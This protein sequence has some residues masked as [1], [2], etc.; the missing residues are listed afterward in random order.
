[1]AEKKINPIKT[2]SLMMLI[3]LLGKVL[4]LI[5]DQ[6]LLYHYGIS[7][8]GEAFSIASMVPRKFLDII[9]A[10][11]ITASFI[12]VFNQYLE[13]KDR[14]KAYGLANKFIT[15]IFI[16]AAIVTAAAALGSGQIINIM[17]AALTPENKMLASD[18]L[19]I[20][21][22]IL[23]ISAVAFSLTG[24]LHSLG[25]FNIPAAMS[26]ISN[27]LIILY[28]VFFLDDFGIYGLAVAFTL[29]WFTQILIQLPFLKKNQFKFL[30]DFNPS[31][32]GIREI[33]SLMLPVMVS[34]WAQPVNVMVNTMLANRVQAGWGLALN[35]ADTLF[36]IISGVFILQVT[37]LIFPRLSRE[38]AIDDREGFGFTMKNTLRVMIYILVPM[39]AGLLIL[40]DPL[41]RLVYQ[42]GQVD[43]ES[44][45]LIIQA[46]SYY[47]IG[48]IGLGFQ[49]VAS[50]G[51]YA[52][53][54]GKTPLVSGI[55]LIIMNG[56][57]SY[58]LLPALNVGGPALASSI[59]ITV[60]AVLMLAV[61]YRGN[62]RVIDKK[63]LRD[64]VFVIIASVIMGLLV[65]KLYGFAAV[66]LPDNF[67][68]QAAAL[69]I[70]V[71]VGVLVYFLLTWIFKVSEAEVAVKIVKK[72]LKI[73]RPVQ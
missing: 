38:S 66:L 5:R 47:S 53:K 36:T 60:A 13:T 10:S 31:D 70:S 41:I 23:L 33:F 57:L 63:M 3:T 37:N 46:M 6:L 55:L 24:I 7:Q 30:F 32:P 67:L 54:D 19:K 20:M 49:T 29:S 27:G 72:A 71:A 4:G 48:I 18:L 42:R 56:L 8:T 21:M 59:S 65:F 16:A 61:L 26:L 28:Y 14:D 52:I 69:L 62:K 11:A 58:A 43:H 34:S 17:G 9:F 44:A 40:S 25:E 22:P 73:I 35:S 68:G 15:L 45:G 12:P 2:V 1:M 50:R 51:L 64:G 39:T